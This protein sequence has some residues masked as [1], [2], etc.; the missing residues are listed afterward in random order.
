MAKQK[1]KPPRAAAQKQK[2]RRRVRA[3]YRGYNLGEWEKCYRV[4]DPRL[5]EAGRVEVPRYVESLAS[6][7]QHHGNITI[8]HIQVSL[9]LD[10]R[11]GKQE[12]RPFAYVYVLWQDTRGAVQVFRER[13]VF[14]AGRWYTRVVGLVTREA[15]PNGST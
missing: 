12:D 5:R 11:N 7:K 8:W 2:L 13:W 6:F 1:V 4:I 15:A 3:F 14:D 9:H 10:V